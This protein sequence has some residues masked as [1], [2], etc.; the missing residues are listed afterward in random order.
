MR[1][2]RVFALGVVVSLVPVA[3]RAEGPSS[4][5]AAPASTTTTTAPAST[6]AT[7]AAGA[8]VGGVARYVDEGVLLEALEVL[9][10]PAADA[11][12][13]AIVVDDADVVRR[14]SL[15]RALVRVLRERQRADI[16]T[17]ALVRARVGALATDP[18]ALNG[19]GLAADHV[20]AASV[21]DAA[22]RA[23][24]Q[25][26]LLST[27]HGDVVGAGE[28]EL[29]AR[30]GASTARTLSVEIACA[31]IAEVVAEAIEG[32]GVAVTN[33]R[34]GVAPLQAAGAAKDARLDR[35]LQGELTQALRARGFLVVERAELGRAMEQLTLQEL[36]GTERVAELG[37]L[38]GAQSLVVGSVSD[39]GDHYVV[40]AR[41]VGVEG[42]VV[43]GA[44]SATVKREGV[45][46][47]AAVETRTPSEAALRSAVAP[48]WGQAYNG[49]GMKALLFG[50]STYGAL[51]S[52][53]ALAGTAVWK[54]QL[55]ELV[56]PKDDLTPEEAGRLT[57]TLREESNVLWTTTAVFGVLSASLW[58]LGVADALVSVPGDG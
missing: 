7:A 24:L 35:F 42:G 20:I 28:V 1:R 6:G 52:T 21:V 32:G 46:E 15:E 4:A 26:K 29:A 3:A 12:R 50:V 39:A 9:L 11:A 5:A 49:E 2:M 16:V 14:T 19:A 36:T 10:R 58:S 30:A 25:L 13:I 22:D 41:V 31:D 54:G 18:G 8:D 51:A 37:Q 55:Y 40:N 57:V 38:L 47:M 45:V 48:G 53:A 34:I 44:A 23:V 27:E 33:H 17:P 56:R 43:L